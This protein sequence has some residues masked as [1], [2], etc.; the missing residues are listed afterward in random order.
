MLTSQE[1]VDDTVR[2]TASVSNGATTS[3]GDRIQLIQEDNAR[4]GSTSLVEDVTDVALGLTEPHTQQFRALDGNEVCGTLIG[5]G[6]GK[7]GLTS[8]RRTI[9]QNTARW[10]QTE[11]EE[12]F[13]VI[14][15]VLDALDEF[16]LDFFQTTNVF[17]TDVGDLDNGNL[18]QSRRV[19]DTQ[20]K[21]EVLHGD[22]KGVE[23]FGIDGVLVEV[24][25]IHLLTD[26]LHGSL[27]AQRGEI[28]S[29]VTVSLGSNG[30]QVDV[31]RKLHVLGVDLQ[32]LQTA[33]RVG[34]T[35]V[36]LTIET[37][38]TTESRV[39]GVGAVSGRHNDNV[40]ASLHAVHEGKE[41]GNNTT[42]DFSVG[43]LTLGCDRVDLI[44]KDDGRR[45]L[46]GFL[47]G[48]AQVR[49]GLTGHLGHDFGTVDQEEES[50][51]LVG[52]GTS[53]QSLTRTGR[54]VHEDTTGRLD[55]N[56]LEELGVAKGQ[57][58]K[59]TDLSHLFPATT[60]V[61][62]TDL[63]EVVLLILALNGL[64]LAVD[65]GVLRYNTV[66]W[67]IHLDNLEFYLPHTTTYCEQV[68]LADGSVGLTEVGGEENVEEGA[69]DTLDGI[70]DGEDSNTLGLQ[71]KCLA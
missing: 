6:L 57:F 32:D 35:D 17:P 53:H 30:L 21:A 4:C 29:D 3:L 40:G 60:N 9:E 33:R 56:G 13:G 66:L 71:R 39:D 63:V 12:L 46:L 2:G 19:R 20:G 15:R 23:N 52:H 11:L 45:V 25:E 69:S 10:R 47:E 44:D 55:T 49:L 43:L 61:I 38:E 64:A 5:N 34:D 14:D 28:G 36:D 68:T 41:L 59:L 54:A 37:S 16:A 7:H 8:T 67:G 31:L 26:L 50:T 42:L 65:D 51:G 48:L 62:V 27:R 1:L 22:T 24:N 70:S 58:D 18:A